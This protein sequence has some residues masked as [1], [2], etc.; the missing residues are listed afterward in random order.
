ML[1]FAKMAFGHL[2]AG[3]QATHLL[4]AIGRKAKPG[5][6]RNR[7]KENGQR[8]EADGFGPGWPSAGKRKHRSQNK[9]I[10]NAFWRLLVLFPHSFHRS[11]PPHARP[12][13][14]TCAALLL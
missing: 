14:L 10:S 6:S 1:D 11:M 13:H 5:Q 12:N 7:G 2:Q 3:V 9:A 4:I 8:G